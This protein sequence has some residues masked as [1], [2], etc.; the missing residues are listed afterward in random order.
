MKKRLALLLL[1]CGLALTAEAA[2]YRWLDRDGV[3]HYSDQPS[4]GAKLV[5]LPE[6]SHYAPPSPGEAT[7]AAG[8]DQTGAPAGA[9]V[10]QS[11]SIVHPA[12]GET[13]H[14]A[15]GDV[16]VLM[17]LEPE[18]RKGDQIQLVLDGL[19]A[20][21]TV[22]TLSSVLKHVERGQH[23]LQAEVLDG[24]GATLMRATPVRF[25]LL[26][27]SAKEPSVGKAPE[28]NPSALSPN[29]APIP[30]ENESFP[31]EPGGEKPP[32]YDPSYPQTPSGQETYPT[33]PIDSKRTY[34]PVSAQPS[35]AFKPVGPKGR[36]SY[37]PNYHQSK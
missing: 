34:P 27:P 5:D 26:M 19:G 22:E 23:T 8:T 36:A 15:T 37:Q 20:R 9:T 6:S 4:P 28:D 14:N 17:V 13:M 10:Y 29:Y 31:S 12:D 7:P 3:V 21:Q 2:V 32:A 18:L 25:Y 24:A 33:S 11:F 30:G 35:G 1:L 16:D